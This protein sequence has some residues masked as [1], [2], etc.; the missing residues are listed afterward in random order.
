MNNQLKTVV[1]TS[2]LADRFDTWLGWLS[3]HD[4]HVDIRNK[5]LN[6]TPLAKHISETTVALVST[7]GVHLK[8]QEP[9]NVLDPRGDPSYRKIP[10]AVKNQEIMITHNHYNHG[11]ADDDINCVFPITPL[12]EL[13]NEG[14][15]GGL[16][17]T[18]YGMMGFNPDPT[19]LLTETAPAI[20]RDLKNQGA[21]LVILSGG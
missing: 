13:K 12:K 16:V 4:G 17:E 8:S 5:V 20:G 1:Y 11:D 18:F 3:G 21:D 6:W 2:S 7:A 14:A 19:Q 15:I 9:Y 10:S